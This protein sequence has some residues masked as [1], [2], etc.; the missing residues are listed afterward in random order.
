[1]SPV[2]TAFSLPTA[3]RYPH[4]D[5]LEDSFSRGFSLLLIEIHFLIGSIN[6]FHFTS[7]EI[8]VSFLAPE[9][10]NRSGRLREGTMNSEDWLPPY[11]LNQATQLWHTGSTRKRVISVCP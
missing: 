5:P 7:S 10:A 4:P 1:R 6:N 2:H 11:T 8:L 9:T 3:H